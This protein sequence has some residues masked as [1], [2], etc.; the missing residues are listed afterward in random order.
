MQYFDWNPEKNESLKKERDIC[1]EEV[2]TAYAEGRVVAIVAH[3]NPKRYPGQK[4]LIVVIR[5]YAYLVPFIE[6]DEKIFL[7]TI[8]PSRKATKEYRGKNK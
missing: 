1:F 2:V 3:H 5:D 8:I 4:L 6:D 7:K